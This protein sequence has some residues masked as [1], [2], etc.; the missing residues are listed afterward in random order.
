MI[1]HLSELK[2]NL[3]REEVYESRHQTALGVTYKFRESFITALNNFCMGRESCL[4][5]SNKENIEL[6]IAYANGDN[7][8]EDM[9]ALNKYLGSL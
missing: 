2:Q 3:S 1:E 7:E 5:K 4:T 9:E 6:F 8:R